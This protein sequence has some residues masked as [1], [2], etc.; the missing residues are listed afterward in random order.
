MERCA[1]DNVLAGC[2]H[3][4]PPEDDRS[5]EKMILS[6]FGDMIT[7]GFRRKVGVASNNS[8]THSQTVWSKQELTGFQATTTKSEPPDPTNMPRHDSPSPPRRRYNSPSPPRRRQDSPSSH[9]RRRQDSPS[10]PRR[11]QDSPSPPR[12]RRQDSPSPDRRRRQ[13]PSPKRCAPALRLC[14]AHEGGAFYR[15]LSAFTCLP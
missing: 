8:R 5:I 10:P 11:R 7:R 6:F 2:P 14:G 13:S 15:C 3:F 1:S 4:F 9:R 12:G